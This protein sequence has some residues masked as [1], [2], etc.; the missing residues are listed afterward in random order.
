M[1][2]SSSGG[3]GPE[4]PV[5]P[6][7]LLLSSFV[8]QTS[9]SFRFP[10]CN[11]EDLGRQP[12]TL[13]NQS[14]ITYITNAPLEKVKKERF[15]AQIQVPDGDAAPSEL[16]TLNGEL[17]NF[18]EELFDI[19]II[20]LSITWGIARGAPPSLLGCNGTF[21]CTPESKPYAARLTD[22]AF[23]IALETAQVPEPG[24]CFSR[25]S[26]CVVPEIACPRHKIETWRIKLFADSLEIG[27]PAK[28]A[29]YLKRRIGLIC[30]SL[31]V[32]SVLVCR[33]CFALYSKEQMPRQGEEKAHSNRLVRA[34]IAVAKSRATTAAVPTRRSPSGLSC[35]Q[36]IADRALHRAQLT[37]HSGPIPAYLQ[38]R[39]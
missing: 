14:G 9:V 22:I 32:S 21:R 25:K 10:P 35:V 4:L 39:R 6:V 23:F 8:R 27:D 26:V 7:Q 28:F 11:Y 17:T 12:W 13:S 34:G 33:T 38:H 15:S 31:L 18:T 19:I 2:N 20:N 30:P 36:N 5:T 3:V 24:R 16:L 1:T 29:N 37:Y